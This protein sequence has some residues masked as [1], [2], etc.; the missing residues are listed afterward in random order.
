[1]FL[2]WC[3]EELWII[4][5][6]QNTVSDKIQKISYATVELWSPIFLFTWVVLSGTQSIKVIRENS[7]VNKEYRLPYS[8]EQKIFKETFR[9]DKHNIW[10]GN[11]IYTISFLDTAGKLI[12]EWKLELKSYY[13]DI[14]LG[15]Y[16]IY[17]N[18]KWVRNCGED[19]WI[20]NF[21]E[22]AKN[23]QFKDKEVI[24]TWEQYQVIDF[25][26]ADIMPY[27]EILYK[28]GND[29]KI[30]TWYLVYNQKLE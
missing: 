15:P 1:M 14:Y 22:T 12:G 24:W 28:S 3:N 17:F 6:T 26:D 9:L 13:Q 29:F 10:Y 8:G 20:S 25:I 18:E 27:W 7:W 23:I 2:L 11:N 5:E 16:T 19:C 21:L 30:T 4:P